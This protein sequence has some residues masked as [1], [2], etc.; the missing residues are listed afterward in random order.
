MLTTIRHVCHQS[1]PAHEP[2]I[3][4]YASLAQWRYPHI[5]RDAAARR[6]K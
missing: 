1:L 2:V 4:P 5:R 3:V 6:D